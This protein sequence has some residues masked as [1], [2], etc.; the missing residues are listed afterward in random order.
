MWHVTARYFAL[1]FVC[2][3]Y[4]FTHRKSTKTMVY[5]TMSFGLIELIVL[6]LSFAICK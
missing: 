6:N 4:F 5:I 2:S 1:Y 3:W